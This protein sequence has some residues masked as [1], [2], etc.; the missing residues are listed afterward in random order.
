KYRFNHAAFVPAKMTPEALTLACHAARKH[1]HHALP[2]T[3][4]GV[5]AIHHP[6]PKEVHKKH[7]MR[8]GV[9]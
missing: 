9:E 6:V 4:Y 5:L 7:G 1:S 8:F 2:A 3:G